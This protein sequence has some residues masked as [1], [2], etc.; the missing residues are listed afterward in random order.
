MNNPYDKARELARS[1]EESDV[2]K[3][4]KEVKSKVDQNEKTKAMI[5]DFQKKQFEIQ[6]KQML[7][8]EP[9]EEDAKKLQE[10]FGILS[11][12]SVANEYMTAEFQYV[13][14]I[15]DVS[16]ILGEVLEQ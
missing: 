5:E 3:K 14:M 9:S 6:K 10:L 7:G 13:Q 16:K 15:Q 2:F 12:D 4:F 1:I 11:L 8:E